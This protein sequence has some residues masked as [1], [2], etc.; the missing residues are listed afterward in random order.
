MDRDDEK[1]GEETVSFFE[2]NLIPQKAAVGKFLWDS[3]IGSGWDSEIGRR[4][5]E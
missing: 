2:V 1:V 3:E 5:L 4:Q